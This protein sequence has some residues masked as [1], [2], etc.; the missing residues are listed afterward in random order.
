MPNGGILIFAPIQSLLS[1]ISNYEED[2][3]ALMLLATLRQGMRPDTLE[4]FV[5]AQVGTVRGI[6]AR[7][8]TYTRCCCD[9]SLA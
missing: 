8:G 7:L 5:V 3:A 4:L 9:A 6:D 1:S 2:C